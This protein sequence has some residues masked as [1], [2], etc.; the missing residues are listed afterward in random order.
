[1][2]LK[3][4]ITVGIF[5]SMLYCIYSAYKSDSTSRSISNNLAITLS[6]FITSF[7]L[8]NQNKSYYVLVLMS[9]AIFIHNI[10]IFFRKRK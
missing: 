7:L 1:M 6:L 3:V 5:L 9:F 4:F 10:N 8:T 2:I